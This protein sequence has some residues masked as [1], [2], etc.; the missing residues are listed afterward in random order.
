[1]QY[2][3]SRRIYTSG[4]ELNKFLGLDNLHLVV[5]RQRKDRNLEK[6]M[7]ESIIVKQKLQSLTLL[8]YPMAVLGL[9]SSSPPLM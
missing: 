6:R 3:T 5:A 9:D 1:M 7:A 8:I 2:I 4:F